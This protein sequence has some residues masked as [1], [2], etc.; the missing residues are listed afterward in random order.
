MTSFVKFTAL[1]GAR[2][3][4]PPC[5]LLEIDEAK[6]LLDCGWSDAFDVEDLGG[7]ARVSKNVD[8]VLLS[9]ADVE[10]VGALPYAFAKLG[11]ACPVYATVPVH[12]MGLLAVQDA[13]LSRSATEPFDLFSAQ[14]IRKAFDKIVQLRYSQPFAL[15]GKNCQGITVT[16][17]NAGHTIGGT[18]WKIKKDT[19]EIVY[20]IDYNHTRERL[21]NPSDLNTPNGVA[22]GLVKPSLMITDAANFYNVQVT[23]RERESGLLGRYLCVHLTQS[24]SFYITLRTDTIVPA[25]KKDQSVL[26]PCDASARVLELAYLLDRTWNE[27]RY[28]YPVCFLSRN[29][30]RTIQYAKS[31]IEWMGDDVNKAFSASR[32][33]PL[34]FRNIQALSNHLDLHKIAQSKVVLAT[35][36]SLESGFSQDLFLDWC[37]NPD[38]VVLLTNKGPPG[39]LARRLYDE[40]NA[41][42]DDAEDVSATGLLQMDLKIP[43]RV[44]RKVPL[45]GEEL[46]AHLRDIQL[47]REREAA[48][49][50]A[51]KIRD[52]ALMDMGEEDESD[53]EYAVETEE[54]RNPLLYKFDAY[55]RDAPGRS[56][57]FFKGQGAFRMFPALEQ[58]RRFDD[59]GEIIN[60]DDY[61][62]KENID[63]NIQAADLTLPQDRMDVD[64]DQREE[65]AV[66]EIPS[67]FV[68]EDRE[69]HVRCRVTYIDFEGLTDGRSIKNILPQIQ[70]RKLILVRGNDETTDAMKQYCVSAVNFTKDVLAPLVNETVNVSMAKNIYQLRLTDTLVSSLKMSKVNDY[71]LAFVDG[72]IRLPQD[73]GDPVLDLPGAD[74]ANQGQQPA[75]IVG[76]LKLSEFRRILQREGITAEFR[77]GGVL[78]C[79]NGTVTVRKV[80][81]LLLSEREN[82]TE[83]DLLQSE[84]GKLVLEGILGKDYYRV[85][86]LLYQAH[87]IL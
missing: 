41:R 65:P 24:I 47:Q 8:A 46:L 21:L 2:S 35:V 81:P 56:G 50:I 78:M 30:Y 70:P 36:P 20:A 53:E 68:S 26:I 39:S 33:N 22:E 57:G 67:K 85:R 27:R 74:A 64:Q 45:E 18:V 10:H 54:A 87:A 71:E 86:T 42:V 77:E 37:S 34:D 4:R 61:T 23:R 6:L 44:K 63:A 84:S 43:L 32:E 3:E 51:A 16:A 13:Q 11:L 40:W 59:Y 48:E 66:P 73:G 82:G 19:D 52:D 17:Y 79:N 7:L 83:L 76:D 25:L 28:Q 31:M 29:S 58:K 14:D 69:V 1:S 12:N 75:V 55:V 15:Q 72:I 9:H 5:F 80:S 38:R 62:S 60:P 49:A